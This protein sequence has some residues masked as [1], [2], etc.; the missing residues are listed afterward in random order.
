[1]K[2]IEVLLLSRTD[3]LA[4]ELTPQQVVEAVEQALTEHAAGTYE[5]H[6]KIGVHPTG[7]DPANFIHAMPAYL[8]Q[9]G[10]CGLKWVAGF[11]KN[12]QRDLPNVTGLQVYNDTATGVPLAVMECGYLTGLRTAAVSAI[13]ARECARPGAATL[14]LAGCGFEGTM[15]LRFI[16]DQI[17][18]IREVRLRD[19]R[20]AAMHDLKERAGKYFTGEIKICEDN[21]SCFDGADVI[22][23]CTNGDEQLVRPEWFLPG[24]FAVGIEGGCAYTAEALHSADKFIVDDI[25]LAEYFDKL[26]RTRLTEDGQPDPEFPG[27]LP[28]I[29]ATIGEVVTKRKPARSSD[30]ER[31]VAIPIGM[32]ICD[33]ALGHLTYRK[34]IEIGVGQKF[35]LA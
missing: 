25:P 23:T 15:H 2:P 13:I 6:P 9:L 31:I 16:L 32:A 5:M 11:A 21:R 3:I 17:P 8:K 12:Y 22:S 18:T 19:I 35:G 30:T 29:Y 33:V 4:L 28:E 1:M 10:A 24:A 26:G 14:A 7:T 20:P 34:A 27:G